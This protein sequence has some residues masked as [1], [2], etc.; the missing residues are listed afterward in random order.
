MA[1]FAVG[2]AEL[3]QCPIL[4]HQGANGL[5]EAGITIPDVNGFRTGA[6]DFDNIEIPARGE[7]LY[8][9]EFYIE[10]P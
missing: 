6:I 4:L 1:P 2:I 9:F 5:P 7:A 3:K 10:A 8:V